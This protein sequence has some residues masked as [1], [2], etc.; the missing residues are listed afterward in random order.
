MK[1]K[2][3]KSTNKPQVNSLTRVTRS[4]Y[5]ALGFY[6]LSIIVFDSG[7]LI[8]RDAVIDR[9]TLA[10]GLLAINT[11]IWYIAS[12]TGIKQNKQH[13]ATYILTTTLL[14]FAG[15]TTY[16][17]RGMASTS[18]IFYVL[19]LLVIATIKNRH[20]LLTTAIVSSA[21]YGYAGVKYFNDFF[22]EGYRVQL[23]GHLVLYVGM[24]F[25]VTWLIMV[26]AGLR[27]DSV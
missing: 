5:F 22:N 3:K 13:I 17:E 1:R 7:N 4:I 15:F 6:V 2:K 18:T 20:A 9:W 14:I 26:I 11:V 19:P 27:K 23:W 10:T 16:W 8:T 21:T 24:I 25:T 12:Q